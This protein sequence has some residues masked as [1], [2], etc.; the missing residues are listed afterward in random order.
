MNLRCSRVLCLMAVL[1]CA[2]RQGTFAED[3]ALLRERIDKLENELS[4][5][6][7][8][9]GAPQ[10]KVVTS[11][12]DV[13]LYGYVKLDAAHD[14][15]RT[16]TGNY[17]R[18]VESSS[19]YAD[20]DQFSMTAN[21]TRLGA[22]VKGPEMQH[23]QTSGL[24]E[25]D[26]YGGG[27]ENKP[28]P[29]MRH[30]YLTAFWPDLHLS[31]LAGQT[32]DTISPLTMPTI[33]YTVGWW[34]GDIGYRR[35]QLRL[36]KT[37]KLADQI[38]GKLEVA[39]ARTLGRTNGWTG[40]SYDTGQEAGFPSWQ[41]R[42][43]VSLPLL[44]NKPTIL[45]VSGHWSEEEYTNRQHCASWSLNA[46][47]TLPITQWLAVQAEGV[48]GENLDAYLGGIGQGI[49]TTTV[50]SIAAHGG[51]VALILTPCA[52]WQFN[53]GAGED[54][55][56]GNDLV[57]TSRTYNNV[58]FGNATYFFNTNFSIGL[59]VSHLQTGYKGQSNGDDVR[60]QLSLMY[61]F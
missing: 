57:A 47:M 19:V 55:P 60:E 28:N 59:E 43:S 31:V 29:M 33:N 7:K 22:Q 54:K 15:D 52:Q 11:G 36:T 16:S 37:V 30:A 4:Q 21:Q 2:T 14:S 25:M 45:G 5:L 49:N 18:W 17:G 34:Q 13:T 27:A 48:V 26:F 24:F 40:A 32:S 20:H 58:L 50:E 3:N 35:P 61:K 44:A 1:V 56:N 46:D 9:L 42:A 39:A 8:Q 51:W 10:K 12:L 41:G 23:L 53:V 38:E 6:K